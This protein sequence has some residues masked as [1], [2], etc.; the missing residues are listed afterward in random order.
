MLTVKS[1]LGF[2]QKFYGELLGGGIL[3]NIPPMFEQKS[4]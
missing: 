2:A 3:E 1:L 4:F